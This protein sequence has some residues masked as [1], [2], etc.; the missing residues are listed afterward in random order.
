MANYI[1]GLGGN[2]CEDCAANDPCKIKPTVT[3][4]GSAS[5]TQ[6]T[7]FSYTITGTQTP[8]SYGATGLPSGLSVNTSTGA[9][10][11]TPTTSGTTSVSISAINACGTGTATLTLSIA[12]CPTPVVTSSLTTLNR[13]IGSAF[14][15]QITASNSPTS[16]GATTLASPGLSLNTSTGVISGTL[17]GFPDTTFYNY[18]RGINACGNGEL[19][20]LAINHLA[21][22][23]A[24]L[25]VCDSISASK[26]KYG[27]AENTGYESSPPKIYLRRTFAGAVNQTVYD[28]GTDC[29]IGAT[30]NGGTTYS[31]YAEY[32]TNYTLTHN[33]LLINGAAWGAGDAFVNACGGVGGACPTAYTATQGT[34]TGDAVCN[35]G[36][37]K[38]T[39]TATD[40][41]SVEFTTA[42]L[43]AAVGNELPAYPN[44]WA[45]ECSSYRNLDSD[46]ITC[47][48]RR[49]R[50]KFQLPNMSGITA[51]GI[52]W[53]EGGVAKSYTWDGV[54]SE[55]PVYTVT[56]PSANGTKQI[57]D[58]AFTCT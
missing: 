28:I 18:F 36:D 4:A 14:T 20:T 43:I 7:A 16:F 6:G 10:T 9:I 12:S 22:C 38:W 45:G 56:E 52:T 19:A 50:Y 25:L 31:G 35:Y 27:Y 53:Q 57:T 42:M 54:A 32:D 40:T 33:G 41:L 13:R 48:I 17:G 23:G 1:R 11:G 58:T 55:T 49:F 21:A 47:T 2:C 34:Q 46:E 30:A 5:G 8:T 3:S 39:G 15:Y 26:S 37:Y 29:L 51:Y 24:P 44:T